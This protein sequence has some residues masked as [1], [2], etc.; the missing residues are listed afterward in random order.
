[1][2]AATGGGGGRGK[3]KSYPKSILRDREL[4]NSMKVLQEKA[5]NLTEQGKEKCPNRSKSLTKEKKGILLGRVGQLGGKCLCPLIK[6]MWSPMS[7]RFG[8]RRRQDY[9]Q[10]KVEDFLLERDDERNEFLTF[11]ES[12]TKIRQGGLN[13]KTWLVKLKMFATGYEEKC[14]SS[15]VSPTSSTT[16]VHIYQRSALSQLY[17]ANSSAFTASSTPGQVLQLQPSWLPHHLEHCRW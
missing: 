14:E 10:M 6:T 12:L 15:K 4:I 11:A 7:Q 3:S 2:Q 8:I 13:V 16:V 9:H 1:M 17:P 5:W